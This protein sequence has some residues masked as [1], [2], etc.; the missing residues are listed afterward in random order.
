M[1]KQKY[2]TPDSVNFTIN[3]K[4]PPS[5]LTAES[6]LLNIILTDGNSALK[7][8]DYVTS[9]VFYSEQNKTIFRACKRLYERG[10]N[11]SSTA[12]TRELTENERSLFE[13]NG[14]ELYIFG[15]T[16][17][18]VRSSEL[19]TISLYLLEIYSKREIVLN[20]LKAITA[21]EN[22]TDLQQLLSVNKERLNE[23]E[24]VLYSGNSFEKYIVGRS[25]NF[26]KPEPIL[27]REEDEILHLK[28]IQMIEGQSGSRKTFLISAMMGGLIGDNKCLDFYSTKPLTKVLFIDTEQSI[29]NVQRVAR[30][31]HTIAGFQPTTD[32][33][34]FLVL[35]LR[36][37]TFRE[38]LEIT[39]K[40]IENYKPDVAFID[41]AK[42]LVADF[43]NIEESA[44]LVTIL[45]KLASKNNC[46]IACVIHQ[47]FGTTKARGHLGSMLYE[48]ASLAISLKADDEITEVSFSKIRNIPPQK[49]A[50]QIQDDET[51]TAIPVL[52]TIQE[53]TTATN[54]LTATFEGL[55][56]KGKY[57]SY[58]ELTNMIKNKNGVKD[59]QAKK[60]ISK[61]LQMGIVHKNDKGHYYQKYKENDDGLPF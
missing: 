42:D 6:D 37:C 22:G 15:L 24:N 51:G 26:D 10:D 29:G 58:T 3:D 49:F 48:K 46:A 59:S 35:S 17:S 21:V 39:V 25:L 50:F 57:I 55:I 45:M 14:P 60:Y 4:Q 9:D 19:E 7:R 11:I 54:R 12:A 52:A 33:S 23:I 34:N 38:R 44:N 43:N 32:Y 40:A 5:D 16:A 61:A 18:Y 1:K 56:E 36:E 13:N 8:V 27:M 30:R 20:S 53:P 31:V 47:N 41:N 2:Y 28:D